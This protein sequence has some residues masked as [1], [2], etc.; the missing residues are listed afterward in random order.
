MYGIGVFWIAYVSI[1]LQ[2]L[3][4]ENILVGATW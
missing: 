2:C 4:N 1:A 3:V